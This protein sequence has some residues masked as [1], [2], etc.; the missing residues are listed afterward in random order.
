M[1]NPAPEHAVDL[2]RAVQEML[3][4][5]PSRPAKLLVSGGIGT[6]KSTVLAAVRAT[7]REAGRTVLT[8]P[9]RPDDDQGA[10]FV[11]DDA[12][13]LADDEIDCLTERSTDPS[14]T[15]VVAAEPLAHRP[16][17][18]ALATALERE[19]PIVALGPMSTAEVGRLLT[20]TLGSTRE[21]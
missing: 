17:L 15:V 2:P 19:N 16:V 5:V 20:A 6:G 13:H 21:M 8:R 18:R 10:V 14:S 9:P 11:I 12:H 7:L 1:A 3:A 4:G